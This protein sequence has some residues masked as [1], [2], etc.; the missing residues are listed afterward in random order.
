[1]KESMDH[2]PPPEGEPDLYLLGPTSASAS[3]KLNDPS[4]STTNSVYAISQH[5]TTNRTE[6][7]TN[8]QGN[9]ENA[10]TAIHS[11][12]D[13]PSFTTTTVLTQDCGPSR[14]G[15]VSQS[16]ATANNRG[17]GTYVLRL[18]EMLEDAEKEGHQ[19]IVSWQPH[20]RAFRVHREKEFVEKIMPRYFKAKMGSFLRWCRAWGF[21]RMTE[22]RDR[23]AWYHR[24]FVRGVTSLS[25]SLSRQQMLKAMEDWLPPGHVPNFYTSGI[26]EVL[27]EATHRPI[28]TPPNVTCKNPKQLR[29]TVPEDLRRMLEDAEQEG[30][31]TIVSWLPHG[32]AFKVHD[33]AAFA[34]YI[35]PRYF[36]ASKF[37]YFSD[38]LRMWGWHRLKEGHDKG[39]Y[40]HRLFIKDQPQLTRHLHRIQMKKNMTPW[41][42]QTGEPNLYLTPVE[43]MD[44]FR[45]TEEARENV[46]VGPHILLPEMQGGD[47]VVLETATIP[48]VVDGS[49]ASEMKEHVLWQEATV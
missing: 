32:R 15:L 11:T 19:H 36:K 40:Y 45:G 33:K 48:C 42:P 30:N 9:E 31:T 28:E 38:A 16:D 10:E 29:G 12:N 3:S 34:A 35:L 39:A 21:V 37:T 22:G 25:R 5:T 8:L 2:W 1:M 44:A 18:H 41:P 14:L 49:D 24:Y 27:S 4:S 23:G 13:D 46:L 7:G 6:D 26:G 20:G 47:V 43:Q 17:D